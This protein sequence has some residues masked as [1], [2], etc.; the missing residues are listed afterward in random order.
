MALCFV[1]D[2]VWVTTKNPTQNILSHPK[3]S[4]KHKDKDQPSAPSRNKTKTSPPIV[5]ISYFC[6]VKRKRFNLK[7]SERQSSDVS[8]RSTWYGIGPDCISISAKYNEWLMT[9]VCA[10]VLYWKCC[11]VMLWFMYHKFN[12]NY[13]PYV[14]C[15][16][17][18]MHSTRSGITNHTI[19]LSI[20]RRLSNYFLSVLWWCWWCCCS[21]GRSVW[22][23]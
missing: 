14:L 18:E 11:D 17:C 8:F 12:W 22:F 15:L 10:I 16:L 19:W 1:F 13:I 20:R 3:S 7:K 23:K 21:V 4:E 2:P 5:F 9:M 6:G